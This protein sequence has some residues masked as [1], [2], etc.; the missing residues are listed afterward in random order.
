[1]AKK[2]MKLSATVRQN[3]CVKIKSNTYKFLEIFNWNGIYTNPA[4][5]FAGVKNLKFEVKR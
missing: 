4:I 1:M 3:I 2:F 5:K